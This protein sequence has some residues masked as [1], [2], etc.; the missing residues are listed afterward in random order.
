MVAERSVAKSIVDYDRADEIYA[1]LTAKYNVNIDDRA[2]EWALLSEEYMFNK[3][4]SSFMPEET[5]IA[6]IGKRLGDRILAR[7]RRDFDM[8]DDIR[9][10]LRNDYVVEIDDGNKEWMIVSPRGAMWD[11]N[12][13]NENGG[14]MNVVSKEEW[15][16]EDDA[17]DDD[18]DDD[19]YM[20][21]D[22]IDVAFD[23]FMIN[24]SAKEVDNEIILAVGTDDVASTLSTLTV[25]E[26]KDRLKEAGLPVCGKKS[27]LIARLIDTASE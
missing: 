8:A 20:E 1:E 10:E 7:K 6:A 19:K 11:T 16:A 3:A 2:C 18:D 5:I 15:D 25:P 21:Q 22:N 27:E 4:E 9:D 24:D 26:L 13:D 12:D 23:D 17:N 14:G